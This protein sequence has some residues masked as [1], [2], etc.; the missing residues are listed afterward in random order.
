M[1]PPYNWRNLVDYLVLCVAFYIVLRWA[2]RARALRIAVTITAFYAAALVARR[3]ELIITSW[4]LQGAALISLALLVVLFQPEIRRALMGIDRQF[5]SWRARGV[6]SRSANQ[7]LADAAFALAAQHV[8]AL[9]V[10]VRQDPVGELVDGGVAMAAEVSPGLIDA[11]FQRSSPLHDGAV[12]IQSGQI[13]RANAILP[14]TQRPDVPPQFG[15][16]HRAAMGLAERTDALVIVVSEER[17]EVAAMRGRSYLEVG[18]ADELALMLDNAMVRVARPVSKR[19]YDAIVVRWQYKIAAVALASLI[20]AVAT[21][22]SGSSVRTINVPVEFRN[23]PRGLDIAS[24]SA[25]ELTVQLRGRTWLLDSMNL[26]RLVARFDLAKAN[27][28]TETVRVYPGML[29]LPPGVTMVRVTPD[30]ITLRL[31]RRAP[32]PTPGS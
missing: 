4:V 31:T 1:W 11:I 19:L 5:L 24:Q 23:V 9:F 7:T 6:P 14:L 2:A 26:P 17:G 22:E 28:G 32:P 21:V 16:R 15:T 27:P 3:F 12:L 10:I 8:G 25:T 13:A 30:A 29:G 20:W 18:S